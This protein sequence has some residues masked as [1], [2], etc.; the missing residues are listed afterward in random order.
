VWAAAYREKDSGRECTT[1]DENMRERSFMVYG[2]A[3]R[4]FFTGAIPGDLDAPLR[5]VLPERLHAEHTRE[6]P[7]VATGI[8]RHF[9]RPVAMIC[10]LIAPSGPRSMSQSA[11][12]M[13]SRLCFNDQ[14]RGARSGACGK[15][16]QLAISSKWRPVVG[17]QECR[18]PRFPY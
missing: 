14:E 2:A 15:R 3:S 1:H 16:Q 4:S 11:A 6:I 8:A 10:R 7:P 13:T 9:R 5:S 18:M 17:R 12:L